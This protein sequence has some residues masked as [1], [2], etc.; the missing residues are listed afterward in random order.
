[1][2][3]TTMYLWCVCACVCVRV[4]L[5]LCVSLDPSNPPPPHTHDHLCSCATQQYVLLND[6]DRVDYN[7]L[8]YTPDLQVCGAGVSSARSFSFN[9]A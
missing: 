9:L 5:C 8:V 4:C 3:T 7:V 1:M 6:G 2:L